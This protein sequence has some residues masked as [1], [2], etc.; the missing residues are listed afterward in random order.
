MQ[1]AHE[2]CYTVYYLQS[3]FLTSIIIFI[4]D[5]RVTVFYL[6]N[7]QQYFQ[8]YQTYEADY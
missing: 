5:T 6:Q 1:V 7:L 2:G 4:L 8:R 3:H